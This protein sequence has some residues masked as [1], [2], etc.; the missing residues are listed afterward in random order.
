MPA[1]LGLL[2]VLIIA[3]TC[4]GLSS[5]PYWRGARKFLDVCSL[6]FNLI[7]TSFI[8]MFKMKVKIKIKILKPLIL[9]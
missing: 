7:G 6:R 5:W 1:S 8:C 2:G 3:P 9:V 4:F